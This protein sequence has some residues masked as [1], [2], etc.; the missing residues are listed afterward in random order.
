MIYMGINYRHGKDGVVFAPRRNRHSIPPTP[1][2]YTRDD[3]DPWSFIMDIPDCTHRTESLKKVGCCKAIV[4]WCKV[5]DRQVFREVCKNCNADP[6]YIKKYSIEH[7]EVKK[8]VSKR[9]D[10]NV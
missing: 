1:P 3:R 5:V 10:A 2:G 9:N 8:D 4:R 6:E 7:P